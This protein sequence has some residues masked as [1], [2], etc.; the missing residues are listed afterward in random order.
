MDNITCMA[1]NKSGYN[2]RPHRK[3]SREETT[4]GPRRRWDDNIKLYL[5]EKGYELVG[6]LYLGQVQVEWRTLVTKLINFQIP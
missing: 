4:S 6:W 2:C 3:T 1:K 5:T